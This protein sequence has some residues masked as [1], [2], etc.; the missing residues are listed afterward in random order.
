[1][2]FL[3]PVTHIIIIII[4]IIIIFNAVYFK[5]VLNLLSVLIDNGW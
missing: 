1:M 5:I 2:I 4:I 3:G